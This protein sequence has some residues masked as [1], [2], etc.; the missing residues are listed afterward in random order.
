VDERFY[1]PTGAE[2]YYGR[3][4][5]FKRFL[6]FFYKVPGEFREPPV[7]SES[8]ARGELTA[9]H[10]EYETLWSLEAEGAVGWGLDH[11]SGIPG[12]SWDF[13][14]RNRVKN[15]SISRARMVRCGGYALLLTLA[16]A[17]P[18]A[19]RE[20]SKLSY[21]EGLIVSVPL[22]ASEVEQVVGDVA[23]NGVIRGTKEYNKDEFVSGAKA[24][25]SSHV[26][27]PWTEGGKVFYK[28]REQALDP[29]NF[30][31]S[32][33]SGTLVVR[34]VVQPQGDKNSVL[35][36]NALFKEDYRHVVHQSNG[37]VETAEYSDIR[38]H[39]EAIELMK[40]QNVD[41]A[42]QQRQERLAK[43]QSLARQ[44]DGGAW[45][46]PQSDPPASTSKPVVQASETPEDAVPGSEATP[47]SGQEPS[48]NQPSPSPV[49]PGQALSSQAP[50]SQS[51]LGPTLSGQSLEDRVKD[52]RKQV[53]RLVRAPG[54]PLKSAPFHT[55]ST[56]QSLPPGTEVLIL[57]STPYWYG[58]ETHDGQHG[59]IMRDELEQP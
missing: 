31:D 5:K 44:A 12:S 26:F 13:R 52:L 54:A 20:K 28:V 43:K 59:W 55:A 38:E 53:E 27:P 33:D 49:A 32:S 30:K 6:H 56:L 8:N 9:L 58:I 40:K 23:Q 1:H 48:A 21:G 14:A 36:I 11:E 57:I 4:K 17:A 42:E 25:T 39:V 37:S 46:M 50:P 15:G 24:A 10:Q 16:A 51:S 41:A 7:K 18:L 3:E 29:R 2:S 35:R 19:G 45:P 34:Y 47:S 22:P